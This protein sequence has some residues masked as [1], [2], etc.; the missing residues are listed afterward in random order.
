MRNP[1]NSSPI[2]KKTDIWGINFFIAGE[3]M[4]NMTNALIVAF[5]GFSGN[6]EKLA[7]VETS[8]NQIDSYLFLQNL[9]KKDIIPI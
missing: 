3:L 8:M 4:F 1:S 6:Y 9:N 2:L 5:I 7:L